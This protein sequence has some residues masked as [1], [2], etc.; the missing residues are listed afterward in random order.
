M[1]GGV[2][3]TVCSCSAGSRTT[4]S[5]PV[6]LAHLAWLPT[7]INWT[8]M[9]SHHLLPTTQKHATYHLQ[10]EDDE[11]DLLAELDAVENRLVPD[12]SKIFSWRF[13][14]RVKLIRQSP[15]FPLCFSRL[16]SWSRESPCLPDSSD[17]KGKGGRE[18]GGGR[19]GQGT[20]VGQT[21]GLSL[22]PRPRTH[23]QPPSARHRSSCQSLVLSSDAS[24]LRLS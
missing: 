24:S 9:G 1:E 16:Q 15:T 20:E 6:A 13:W 18:N 3:A 12:W 11:L 10:E 5:P 2:S 21:G 8:T 17:G 14:L 7:L 19:D 22:V 23:P 4:A